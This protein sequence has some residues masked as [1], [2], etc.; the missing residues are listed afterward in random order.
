MELDDENHIIKTALEFYSK[1]SGQ[2][3]HPKLSAKCQE[4][5]DKFKCDSGTKCYHNIVAE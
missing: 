1:I 3:K 4:I 5:A 2:R